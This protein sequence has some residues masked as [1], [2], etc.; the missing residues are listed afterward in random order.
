MGRST[1]LALF[2][3]AACVSSTLPAADLFVGTR[4][5][6][7]RFYGLWEGIDAE[8]GSGMQRSITQGPNGTL[9][10]IGRETYF[11]YCNGNPGIILGTG[12]I[13]HGRAHAEDQILRCEDQSEVD[14]SAVYEVNFTD[15]T[16]I[17]TPHDPTVQPFVYHKISRGR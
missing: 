7:A 13:K 9:R 6:A 10:I 1:S 11:S 17:E 14:T 2:T 15:G 3:I 5:V 16:L 8:D 4:A 12:V